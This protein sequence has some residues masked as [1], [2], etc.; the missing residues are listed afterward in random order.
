MKSWTCWTAALALMLASVAAIAQPQL[1]EEI[2]TQQAQ[3]RAGLKAGSGPY[4]KLKA[5]ERD[6]LLVKQAAM[7]RDI[8]GKTH[9]DELNPDVRTSV[10]NTLELIEAVVNRE[11]DE[12]LVCERRPILGSTRKQRVCMTV[13]Q[14]R[15]A[16]ERAREE[17][18]VNRIQT[19]L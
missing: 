7:L 10:F 8:E 6:D 12:R 3:I 19:R 16:Q 11:D 17:M 5:T 2:R 4:A 18:D 15:E 1:L 14:R 9:V 13:G